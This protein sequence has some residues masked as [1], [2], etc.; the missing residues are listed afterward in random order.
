MTG[1]KTHFARVSKR[2]FTAIHKHKYVHITEPFSDHNR[3]TPDRT[4]LSFVSQ[5]TESSKCDTESDVLFQGLEIL[6]TKVRRCTPR[7]EVVVR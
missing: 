5:D 7:E 4:L 2:S 1:D 3:V 6:T